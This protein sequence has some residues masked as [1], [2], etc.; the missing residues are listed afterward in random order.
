MISDIWTLE[1][2]GNPGAAAT[3]ADRGVTSASISRVNQEAGTLT[4]QISA[5]DVGAANLNTFTY[6]SRWVLRREGEVYFRGRVRTVPRSSSSGTVSVEIV[7]A[8]R[9]LEVPYLQAWDVVADDG[10]ITQESIP[11]ALLSVSA[12]RQTTSQCL[13]AALAAAGSMGVWISLQA[14]IV[15]KTLPPIE[16]ANLSC[17]SLIRQI[18]Q[19]HPGATAYIHYGESSD[20]LVVIDPILAPV[21]TFEVGSRPLQDFDLVRRDDLQMANCHVFYSA[22]ATQFSEVAGEE[23]DDPATIRATRRLAVFKDVWPPNSAIGEDSLVVELPAPAISGNPP[24]QPSPQMVAIKTTPIPKNGADDKAAEKFWLDLL[25]LASLGVVPAD[26]KLPAD[27]DE[28]Q[29][30][31]VRFAWEDEDEGDPHYEAPSAINPNSTPLW[32]PPTVEDIPNM[33]KSG[34]LAEWMRVEAAELI[35]DATVAIRKSAAEADEQR[36]K[37]IL[38]LGPRTGEV[39]GIPAYLIDASARIVGTN[40]RTKVY[41]NWTATGTFTPAADTKA[42]LDAAREEAVVPNLAR[43]LYTDRAIAPWEGS[44]PLMQQDVGEVR[45]LGRVINLLHPDRPEWETMRA[46]VQAETLDLTAGT[47]QIRVGPPR[48]LSPQD[49]AALYTVA[50]VA[51]AERAE[52]APAAPQPSDDDD[53]EDLSS[54]GQGGVFPGTIPPKTEVAMP[55]QG[56][57]RL[58]DV[59]VTST[60]PVKIK[61][62]CPG[63]VRNTDDADQSSVVEI[64]DEQVEFTMEADDYL[65]LEWTKT[66]TCT[67]K[68]MATWDGHPYPYI[69]TVDAEDFKIFD[70]TIV[71]LW[72]AKGTGSVTRLYLG[73]HLPI[74]SSLVLEKLAPDS[75]FEVA[76]YLS[77]HPDGQLVDVDR[78]WPGFGAA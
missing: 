59:V 28:G 47:T 74:S 69:V 33:L 53:D 51:R 21:T 63:V 29:P 70:K 34:T 65:V 25:G 36:L 14:N 40:A 35:V 3:L 6:K 64:V 48:H 72:K 44:I 2:N 17:A 75:H 31:R 19:Y 22:A 20:A 45:Y 12:S 13:H 76:N 61:L 52:A 15:N 60:S 46:M 54:P 9:D 18:L 7:D 32:R 11:R 41:R 24:T 56:T 8:W 57:P 27:E 39:Q 58:W 23:E 26:V 73:R 1:P 10:S 43:A 37:A 50:R 78:F 5:E 68:K 66:G 49:R 55:S 71:P 16:A 67:L 4:L 42:S 77:E 38:K 30:H 62:L